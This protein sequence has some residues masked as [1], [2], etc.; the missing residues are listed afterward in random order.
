[1][2][3]RALQTS[4]TIGIIVLAAAVVSACAQSA[5]EEPSV[6]EN[7][8]VIP[9]PQDS[10]EMT[11]TLPGGIVPCGAG[12]VETWGHRIFRLSEYPDCE[13]YSP[14]L[15]V[16]CMDGEGNWTDDSVSDVAVGAD[17]VSFEAM[18]TG[19]CALFP[20]E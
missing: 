10:G 13:A 14:N 15:T 7:P 3:K 6:P 12:T 8:Y 18:Q 4:A 11:V 19:V 2:I 16:Y 9:L 1:M 20:T 17:E 5:E